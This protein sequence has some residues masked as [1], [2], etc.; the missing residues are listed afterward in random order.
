MCNQNVHN[1]IYVCISQYNELQLAHI[2]LFLRVKGRSHDTRLCYPPQLRLSY[3]TPII[4]MLILTEYLESVDNSK[5]IYM[6]G[7]VYSE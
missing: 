2:Q 1:M 4:M 7:V 6:K 3:Y 5:L